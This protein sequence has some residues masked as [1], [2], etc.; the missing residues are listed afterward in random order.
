MDILSIP[1]EMLDTPEKGVSIL[2][3][4]FRI[5]EMNTTMHRW[6]AHRKFRPGE[7]CYRM[8]HGRNT[9]CTFC[10]ARNAF[11]ERR[12][13]TG[14]VPYHGPQREIRGW[15]KLIVFP[16]CNGDGKIV[17]VIEY[18]EDITR[19]KVLEAEVEKLK[20][21]ERFLKGQVALLGEL[22]EKEKEEKRRREEE[23]RRLFAT[24]IR[25]LLSLLRETLP[26]EVQRMLL[27]TLEKALDSFCGGQD[28]LQVFSLTPR[29]W[30]VA[31]LLAQGLTSK[32]IAEVLSVSKKAVDF[33]RGNIRKKLGIQKTKESLFAALQRSG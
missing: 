18:V 33:H 21:T 28:V 20:V 3:T 27:D 6:Y 7:K 9:P 12:V 30:E 11:Q 23:R 1:G 14:I 13:A 22:L 31:R 26:S 8:Y 5:L 24:G 29:E 16:L 2:D 15:Q 10:P 4:S 19:E 25:P 32:E 17:G